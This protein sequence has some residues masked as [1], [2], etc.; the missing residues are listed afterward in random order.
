M[1]WTEN[2]PLGTK[3]CRS[4]SFMSHS[5]FIGSYLYVYVREKGRR[6]RRRKVFGYNA[7]VSGVFKNR[8]ASTE[9]TFRVEP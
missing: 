6:R 8:N 7:Y 1:F 5:P 3:V 4:A 9:G 2:E